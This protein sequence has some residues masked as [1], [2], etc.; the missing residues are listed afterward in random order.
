MY[1]LERNKKICVKK[2][3]KVSFKLPFEERY[4]G[5]HFK[6]YPKRFFTIIYL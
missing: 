3:T 2:E 4:E 6:T 1:P 5:R